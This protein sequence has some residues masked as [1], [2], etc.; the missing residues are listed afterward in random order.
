MIIIC[1]LYK[2]YHYREYPELFANI[3]KYSINQKIILQDGALNNHF[4]KTRTFVGTYI[5]IGLVK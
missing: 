2:Q 4:L 5:L 1:K 3:E